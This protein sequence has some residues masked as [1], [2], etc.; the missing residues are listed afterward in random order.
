[1]KKILYLFFILPWFLFEINSTVLSS[2]L[3]NTN[4]QS[5]NFKHSNCNKLK[6]DNLDALLN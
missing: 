5:K 4:S 3:V 6:L 1:M 2:D